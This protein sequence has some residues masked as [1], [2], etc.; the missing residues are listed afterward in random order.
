LG[1]AQAR[2]PGATATSALFSHPEI[3]SRRGQTF[4][5]TESQNL[6]YVMSTKFKNGKERDYRVVVAI[7]GSDAPGTYEFQLSNF[8]N[9]QFWFVPS[10][11]PLVQGVGK[12]VVSGDLNSGTADVRLF[13]VLSTSLGTSGGLPAAPTYRG[14]WRCKGLF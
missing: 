11:G 7:M 9:T 10:S 14:P 13:D 12:I 4:Q 3:F 6:V 2:V 1:R 5:V 8:Q